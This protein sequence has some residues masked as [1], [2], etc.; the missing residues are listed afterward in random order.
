MMISTNEH[1]ADVDARAGADAV[2]FRPHDEH[3]CPGGRAV[4]FA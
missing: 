4:V 2:R 3:A 1:I